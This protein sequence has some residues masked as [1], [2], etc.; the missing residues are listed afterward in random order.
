MKIDADLRKCMNIKEI[1]YKSFRIYGNLWKSLKTHEK[2][3]KFVE[4]RKYLWDVFV[5]TKKD[6]LYYIF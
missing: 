2:S 3:S 1:L 5:L 4:V 6:W